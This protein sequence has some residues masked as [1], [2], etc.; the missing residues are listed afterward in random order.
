MDSSSNLNKEISPTQTG[1]DDFYGAVVVL[2]GL[3]VL[4]HV[5]ESRSNVV[6]GL[7]EQTTVRRQV[8]QLQGKALLEVL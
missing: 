1:F 3:V 8:L 5:A 6:V 4:I 7:R 2:D